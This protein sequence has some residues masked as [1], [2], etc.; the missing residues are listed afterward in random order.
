MTARRVR[1]ALPIWV[2]FLT[3]LIVSAAGLAWPQ[4][5]SNPLVIATWNVRGYP[6]KQ[7]EARAWFHERLAALGADVLCMQEIANRRK[8]S[9]FL[10]AET[11]FARV[12]FLDSRDSQ[13]NAIFAAAQMELDDAPD[14]TG[15][16]HPAQLAFVARQGFDAVVVSVHLSWKDTAKREQEKRL[17]RLLVAA[18]QR[19]D[20]DVI[21]AGDFNT[22]E[23]GMAE[24]AAATGTRLMVP[25]GQNGVGT[26]HAGNRYDHFLVTPDLSNEEAIDCRIVT[27]SGADLALAKKVSDHLPVVARFKT[28]EAFRDR[29]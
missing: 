23:T 20:P 16:Q 2:V 12:A 15:F 24:L 13:D 18:A 22:T 8:V 1:Y 14:P 26:T 4:N 29:P 27:F 21:V 11:S 17:L 19:R 3:L 9:L 28:D 6:E 7:P 5:G 25:V 10:A